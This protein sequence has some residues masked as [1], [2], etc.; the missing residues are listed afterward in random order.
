MQKRFIAV[1]EDQP[2]S[3]WL[4]RFVAGREEAERWYRGRGL[5]APP[6]GEDAPPIEFITPGPTL[7]PGQ[8]LVDRQARWRRFFHSGTLPAR[9]CRATGHA[10]PSPILATPLGPVLGGMA[11][12]PARDVLD[13]TGGLDGVV[14]A[15]SARRRIFVP[16]GPSAVPDRHAFQRTSVV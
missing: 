7:G 9:G 14:F 4:A 10:R 3:A 8:E 13:Y 6:S 15:Q 5:T 16:C 2:G 12:D 1:R 11:A